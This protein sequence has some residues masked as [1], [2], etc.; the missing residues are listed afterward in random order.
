[1]QQNFTDLIDFNKFCLA[2]NFFCLV[3]MLCLYAIQIH[4]EWFIIDEM[5]RLRN[6]THMLSLDGVPT[7]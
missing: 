6:I 2:F 5:V 1:M 4:R 3:T 7:L